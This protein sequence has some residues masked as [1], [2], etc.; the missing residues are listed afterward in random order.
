MRLFHRWLQKVIVGAILTGL[1]ATA[2]MA[3][4]RSEQNVL[5]C[6]IDGQDRRASVSIVGSEAVYRY[7]RPGAAPELV[8]TSPLMQV[9]YRRKN[10]PGSTIDEII[11]FA[12]GDT[13]YRIAAGFRDG[14]EPDP[15]AYIPF[16]TVTVRRA[17]KD[18]ARL[19]CRPVTIE[20]VHDRLLAH[21]R[22]IGR[23]RSSDGETFPNYDIEY[24]LPAKQ[25]A[26]CQARNNVDTCWSRGVGAERSGDLRGALEHYDMSCDARLIT[27]GC[28]E[29]GKLYLQKRQLRDYARAKDRFGRVCSGDDP[30]QGPYA[31]KYLGWMY[32]TGVGAERDRNVARVFLAKA[33]FLQNE[34]LLID[35][36]GCHFLA[37]SIL[38]AQNGSLSSD[39]HVK[40]AAYLALAMGCTDNAKTVCDEAVALYQRETA[41]RAGWIK[42][43]DIQAARHGPIISCAK[44]ATIDD[45][46]DAA[47]AMRRQMR[48]LFVGAESSRR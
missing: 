38:E 35:P 22:E 27:A 11:T 45:D 44:L 1:G 34:D 21:M 47:Q 28:Y 8:L 26:A 6:Q 5:S 33:C 30:G 3:K 42:D 41:R 9:D 15:S 25:S 37:Q 32:L 7:G 16:G 13:T 40:Y 29:A 46:Y 18:L 31:C 36:E 48:D 19:S 4:D 23:E 39:G 10:G 43:C 12:N 2:A 14:V 24:P 17:G 20:R